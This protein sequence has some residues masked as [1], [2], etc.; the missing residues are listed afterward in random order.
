MLWIRYIP[1]IC[2]SEIK[3][4][5][6]YGG[7]AMQKQEKEVS[8]KELFWKILF[9]WKCLLISAIVVAVL[10][11]GVFYLRDW[12]TYNEKSKEQTSN[13]VETE[14]TFSE[15]EEKQL[16][17]A[18][19]LKELISDRLTYIDNS[20]KMNINASEENVLVM[21]WYIESDYQFNYNEDVNPDYT[22]ALISAYE[23]YVQ[24]GAL[25][26]K[27]SED[28]ELE[29]DEKYL[30]EI[31]QV[32]NPSDSAVFTLEVIYPDADV[33]QE[34]ETKIEN[35]MLQKSAEIS[36]NV[37]SHTLKLLSEDIMVRADAEL[38]EYQKNVSNE[39][40]SYQN[41]LNNIKNS[42]S[43]EQINALASNEK[44]QENG[45]SNISPKI[46]LKKPKVEGKKVILG[47]I[48]GLFVGMAWITCKVIFST[49]L[50][51]SED[52]EELYGIRVLGVIEKPAKTGAVNKMLLKLKNCGKKQLSME[53]V[54][55]II[56]S[57]IILECERKKCATIYLTG[58]EVEKMDKEILEHIIHGLETEG[59]KVVYGENILYDPENLRKMS[60]IGNV[61][62]LEQTALSTYQEV[63]KEIKTIAEQG[64]VLIGGVMVDTVF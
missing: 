45:Q 34:L 63:E 42:M 16:Q 43:T 61:V 36:Q 39:V 64:A 17:I 51:N 15:A 8:V 14:N 19:M 50:Q 41:W 35:V 54:V 5:K 9:S 62:L 31:F 29:H 12:K 21:T 46:E 33:L 53:T 22:E 59:L 57:N 6:G 27:M 60:S 11:V 4:G 3:R 44:V 1:E 26:Q 23:Q 18:E 10:V 24:G 55:D 28:M 20:V 58:S 13:K 38:V 48:L 56:L 32:K 52:L 47:L 30:N 49:K 2:F 37:G 7:E 25:A 40:V